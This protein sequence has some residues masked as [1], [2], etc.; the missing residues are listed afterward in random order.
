MINECSITRISDKNRNPDN[1]PSS[2]LE[3]ELITWFSS[4]NEKDTLIRINK[5]LVYFK[6]IY[7]GLPAC[8][9]C[10]GNPETEISGSTLV[11]I[12][13]RYPEDLATGYR[14]NDFRGMWKIE[15]PLR[16]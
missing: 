4:G 7:V 11:I 2:Q 1:H 10:H 16:D 12:N 15:F 8:L 6:P 13:E 5:S 3:N 9:Q 14:L